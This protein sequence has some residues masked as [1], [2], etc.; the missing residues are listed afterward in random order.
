MNFI[1]RKGKFRAFDGETEIDSDEDI[2][3]LTGRHLVDDDE[4]IVYIAS[5]VEDPCQDFIGDELLW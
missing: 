4:P 2:G 3:E 1:Y 5:V